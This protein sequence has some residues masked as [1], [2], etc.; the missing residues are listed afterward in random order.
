[1][2]NLNWYLINILLIFIVV[3]FGCF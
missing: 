1:M 2:F 3:V